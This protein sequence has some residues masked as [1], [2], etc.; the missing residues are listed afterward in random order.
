M[1]AAKR[2][3]QRDIGAAANRTVCRHGNCAGKGGGG[4]AV[5]VDQH[6]AA[7]DAGSCDAE[8]GYGF[9]LTVHVKNAA[10]VDGGGDAVVN[11]VAAHDGCQKACNVFWR[12]AWLRKVDIS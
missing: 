10:A 4:G 11:L 1:G 12:E 2:A 9:G 5:V 3:R 7:A 6:P 8:R